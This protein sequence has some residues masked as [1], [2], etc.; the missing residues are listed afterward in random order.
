M[1]ESLA[2]KVEKSMGM[3][4]E[5]DQHDDYEPTTEVHRK[6]VKS[7]GLVE[8]KAS[9]ISL[10][11]GNIKSE[12]EGTPSKTN[13]EYQKLIGKMLCIA[14]KTRSPFLPWNPFGAILARRVRPTTDYD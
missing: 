1:I 4:V 8:A 3:E 9:K 5:K 2:R 13:I 7:S 6:V 11:P 12:S 14:V 10:D